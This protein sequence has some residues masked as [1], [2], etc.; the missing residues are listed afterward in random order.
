M[1]V[2]QNSTVYVTIPWFG[3]SFVTEG[4]LCEEGIVSVLGGGGKGRS[5]EK[6]KK[7]WTSRLPDD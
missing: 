6:N 1:D 3:A 4:L 7:T 5:V 2:R